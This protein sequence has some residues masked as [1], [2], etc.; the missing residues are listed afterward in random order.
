MRMQHRTR[1]STMPTRL[2]FHFVSITLELFYSLPCQWNYWNVIAIN[3]VRRTDCTFI[4]TWYE[5]SWISTTHSTWTMSARSLGISWTK[6]T[7]WLSC[8]TL[9]LTTIY[10]LI[11]FVANIVMHISGGHPYSSHGLRRESWSL[12]DW[13]LVFK[14]HSRH[15]LCPRLYLFCYIYL[16]TTTITLIN[17]YNFSI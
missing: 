10:Q 11:S 5:Q 1:V 13:Y 12:G 14:C 16:L 8:F 17:N 4:Y 3:V 15:G 9:R 7:C 2:P 6:W